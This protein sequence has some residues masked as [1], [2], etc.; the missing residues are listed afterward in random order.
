MSRRKGGE[1][2]VAEGGWGGGLEVDGGGLQACAHLQHRKSTW[3]VSVP[4]LHSATAC[5]PEA[6]DVR[7]VADQRADC[8]KG[9]RGRGGGVSA[10]RQRPEVEPEGVQHG[11]RF[12]AAEPCVAVLVVFFPLNSFLTRFYMHHCHAASCNVFVVRFKNRK[13]K[14]HAPARRNAPLCC[15]TTPEC[16]RID[17]SG[18]QPRHKGEEFSSPGTRFA[19]SLPYFPSLPSPVDLHLALDAFASSLREGGRLLGSHGQP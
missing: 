9:W 13:G 11:H 10:R 15:G 2:G 19:S 12:Q 17:Q 6:R 1:P 7:D 14:K 8:D 3:A 18:I 4:D 5:A 16:A